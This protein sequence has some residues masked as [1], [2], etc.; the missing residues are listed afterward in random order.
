MGLFQNKDRIENKYTYRGMKRILNMEQRVGACLVLE[1]DI[2]PDVMLTRSESTAEIKTYDLAPFATPFI[3]IY[4]LA[5]IMPTLYTRFVCGGLQI[6]LVGMIIDRILLNLCINGFNF[7]IPF[8][9]IFHSKF[10]E[11]VSSAFM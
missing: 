2:V 9:I 4:T 8:G 6:V 11:H 1:G 5:F 7:Q 10:T 3:N